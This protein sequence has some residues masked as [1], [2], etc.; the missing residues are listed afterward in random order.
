MSKKIIVTLLVCLFSFT[1]LSF[2][3][4]KSTESVQDKKQ[5]AEDIQEMQKAIKNNKLEIDLSDATS[6]EKVVYNEEG[7]EI[8]VMGI[9]SV[10]NQ[11]QNSYSTIMGIGSTTQLPR[12]VV[13]T[14]K[15]YWYA[16]TVNYSFYTQ[17]YVSSATGRGEIREAYDQWYLAIPPAIISRDTLAITRKY[18][19][20]TLP[21]EAKYT[22]NFSAP[23]STMLYIYGRVQDD[24]FI[25]GGN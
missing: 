23:F 1:N 12:G 8:G 9:E 15:V 18:E 2:A 3:Q 19:T 5:V 11:L 10:E 22:L 25:T 24:K 20:S 7:K 13:K 6:V 14:F 21:A 17:V 16:A 4:A